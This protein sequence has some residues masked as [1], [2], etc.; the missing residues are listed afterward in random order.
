MRTER[1]SL[2]KL[3]KMFFKELVNSLRVFKKQNNSYF[4]AYE[5][6]YIPKDLQPEGD[7]AFKRASLIL[8][9]IVTEFLQ[10][11]KN[12]EREIDPKEIEIEIK[13]RLVD[14]F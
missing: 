8:W 9:E 14:L 3:E 13:K 12:P 10:E 11:Y 5:P 2:N 7:A 6:I 1:L 4:V